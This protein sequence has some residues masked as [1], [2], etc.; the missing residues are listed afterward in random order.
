MRALVCEEF[1]PYEELSV[2]DVPD[3]ELAEG[4]VMVDVKAAGVNFPDVLL[5]E[6]KYQMKPPTPF[7][8]GME[9][10]GVVSAL[11]E[12]VQGVE[13][14]QRV[15][16]ATMLGAFA[17]KVPAAAN[18]LVPMPDSMSFEEGAAFTTIYGTSYHALKQ[19]ADLKKGETILV[20]G[21][22]GGVGLA[23][24]Q[25][26]KAMGATVIAAASSAEKLQIAS[27]AGADHLINYAE[28]DLKKAVKELT[29]GKG[30]DVVYDP[31]GGDL[32]EPALRA[33]GWGARY[34]VIGFAA[35]DIPK[36]PLNLVLL[37]S[38]D[39]RGV[40]WGSWAGQ[41]PRENAQNIKELFDLYEAGKIK[42]RISASYDLE[43]F[44]QAFADIM[45]RRVKG[46]VVL[47]T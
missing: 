30:V 42:P 13:I 47:T 21:A 9:A 45:E 27:D 7:V 2:H 6:G 3:P 35:G 19:R 44:K 34:L 36:I 17:E 38:R 16:V 24:V 43:E 40:F 8:P 26:A 23:T 15:I 31:V 32:A 41:F 11:G 4:M 33:T 22:A 10:S 37:N 39:I 18:Q 20:L 1:A 25:I 46:K 14:G 12:G 29:G 28:D 5:V